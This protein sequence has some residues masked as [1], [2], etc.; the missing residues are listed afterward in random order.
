MLLVIYL[1]SISFRRVCQL[2]IMGSIQCSLI[3]I[4]VGQAK[5]FNLG[6]LRCSL[7]ELLPVKFSDSICSPIFGGQ[8]LMMLSI[9]LRE[10][11][12]QLLLEMSLVLPLQLLIEMSLVLPLQLLLEMSLVLGLTNQLGLQI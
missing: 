6:K 11:P 10:L 8:C 4:L 2:L 9:L 12:L 3:C 7:L 1:Q 5:G